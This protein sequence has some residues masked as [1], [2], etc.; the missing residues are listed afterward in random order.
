ME[1]DVID[2]LAPVVQLT[3]GAV[4]VALSVFTRV[5]AAVALMPGF[6]ERNLPARVKTMAAVMFALII[7]PAV[8]PLAGPPPAD[9]IDASLALMA[10]A[11]A[12]LLL[13]LSVRLLVIAL[14][15]AGAISTQA[16]SLSQMFGEGLTADP[17]PA[18]ANLLAISG[19]VLAFALG[20]PAHVAAALIH[21][22][23]AIP[24]GVFPLGGEIADWGARRVNA[25]F[26]SATAIAAPFIV[27]SFAYNIG[28]GAINRAMPQLMVAFV[29]APAISCAAIVLMMLVAPL[30]LS[31]WGTELTTTLFD[32]F[33]IPG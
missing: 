21:S 3:E 26:M 7:W 8:H 4:W 24:F 1:R 22:Y 10:E 13:G 20:L 11:T 14:Q 29:G 27:A 32:P 15:I 6:G 30:A 33:G 17:Q 12:G 9:A 16:T 2:L 31:V 28:I 19:I 25:A 23:E 18:Y 5:G